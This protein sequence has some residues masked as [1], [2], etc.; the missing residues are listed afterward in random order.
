MSLLKRGGDPFAALRKKDFS[1]YFS[2]RFFLT[3]GIQ[4]QSTVVGWH[5]YKLTADPL[6]IGL[7]GAA[8]AIPFIFFS[9]FSGPLADRYNR[10]HLVLINYLLLGGQALFLLF[11]SMNNSALIGQ[12]GLWLLYFA[13]ILWG[14]IRAFIGP[15]YQALLAQT[16]PKEIMGNATTWSSFIWHVAAILGP[17][18]GGVLCIFYSFSQV[19]AVNILFILLSLSLFLIIRPRVVE[20]SPRG[21]SIIKSLETGI[22]FVIGNK[23]MFGAISL[24][25]LAVLFGGAVAMLPV[26]ADRVIL[27]EMETAAEL[28]FLR[29]APAAGSVLMSAFLAFFPPFRNAGRNLLV[30]VFIFGILTVAFPFSENLW[31]SCGILFM[32]G[33][34]DNISV[35]IRHTIIQVLTP[36]DMRGRVS[37]F[38]GIFIGSSNEIGALESGLAATWMGLRPSVV[39]GG[40]MTMIIVVGM[41]WYSTALRKLDL[42]KE[43][44]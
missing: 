42:R 13:I 35:V 25:M 34:F 40:L 21:E 20:P 32:I 5:I 44:S 8:E 3:L 22:R 12:N 29:A 4:M 31:L 9:F 15:A 7:L 24:D 10:K 41:G 19:Y 30:S 39:F 1:F 33:A 16:V 23:A 43:T 26:F 17:M 27:S 28:G 6:A 36:D 38:N 2:A 11:I 37:A 14:I 18:V